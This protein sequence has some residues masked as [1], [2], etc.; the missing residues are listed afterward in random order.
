MTQ[1]SQQPRLS[2]NS[3]L[4][5]LFF[6]LSDDSFLIMPPG[7]SE[8]GKSFAV[9]YP[10]QNPDTKSDDSFLTFLFSFILTFQDLISSLMCGLCFH[11]L[12]ECNNDN[13]RQGQNNSAIKF[14]NSEGN[15]WEDRMMIWLQIPSVLE[16]NWSICIPSE[17]QQPTNSP[18]SSASLFFFFKSCVFTPLSYFFFLSPSFVPPIVSPLSTLLLFVSRRAHTFPPSLLQAVLLLRHALFYLSPMRVIPSPLLPASNSVQISVK[19]QVPK[20]SIYQDKHKINTHPT[21]TQHTGSSADLPMTLTHAVQ[22]S[23][24]IRELK[25]NPPFVSVRAIRNASLVVL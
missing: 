13:N 3:F 19:Q 25:K 2:I 24:V 12:T 7:T 11:Q 10:C 15:E 5:Y 22:L 18:S 21:Q 4:F 8:Q 14:L 23:L 9:H 20:Y 1:D 6:S 17:N 16:V